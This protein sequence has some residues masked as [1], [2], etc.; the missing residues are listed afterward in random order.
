[1]AKGR[2]KRRRASKR[3][4]CEPV[5]PPVTL[6]SNPPVPPDDPEMTVYARLKPKPRP[7]SGDIGLPQPDKEMEFRVEF[8]LKGVSRHN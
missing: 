7:G 8:V 5:I 3:K 1:M 6:P 2:D 4:K